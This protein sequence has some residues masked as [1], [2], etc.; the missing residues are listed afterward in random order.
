MILSSLSLAKKQKKKSGIFKSY[1]RKNGIIEADKEILQKLLKKFKHVIVYFYSKKCHKCKKLNKLFPKIVKENLSFMEPNLIPIVR[2]PCSK[3]PEYCSLSQKITHFPTIRVYYQQKHFTTYLS[4][5]EPVKLAKF[6]TQRVFYSSYVIGQANYSMDHLL[7]HNQLVVL[8]VNSSVF[9]NEA[10]YSQD[11]GENEETTKAQT[12]AFKLLGFRTHHA[13]FYYSEN[14][15]TTVEN[16]QRLC[17]KI[18]PS[19]EVSN[20]SFALISPDDGICYLF[21]ESLLHSRYDGKLVAEKKKI[22]KAL[23]FIK[24]HQK[25]LIMPFNEKTVNEYAKKKMPFVLYT[26]EEGRNLT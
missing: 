5:F 14:D 7:E 4:K 23:E 12:E 3:F 8:K 25:P 15:E 16:Y 24:D 1:P 21:T 10:R 6:L 13:H 17:Q 11:S 26:T 20:A 22:E 18:N 19:N 2:F 9:Q